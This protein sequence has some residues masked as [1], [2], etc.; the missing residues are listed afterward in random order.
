MRARCAC[1]VVSVCGFFA[2]KRQKTRPGQ[3]GRCPIRLGGRRMPTSLS[4]SCARY[5]WDWVL[6]RHTHAT[7]TDTDRSEHT[8]SS[9]IF[10][11][12]HRWGLVRSQLFLAER[13]RNAAANVF[14]ALQTACNTAKREKIKK[15][16]E[17]SAK[18]KISKNGPHATLSQKYYYL[19][20]T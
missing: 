10:S 17:P 8:R 12:W 4:G 9:G 15:A 16:N 14:W 6:D 7:R 5:F 18:S 1:C 2:P 11:G 3:S 20:S 13:F 19:G